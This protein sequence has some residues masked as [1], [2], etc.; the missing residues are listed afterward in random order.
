MG[1]RGGVVGAVPALCGRRSPVLRK[2]NG[3]PSYVVPGAV[4]CASVPVNHWWEGCTDGYR[5]M[6][7]PGHILGDYHDFHLQLVSLSSDQQ[8]LVCW[9]IPHSTVASE[10]TC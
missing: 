6:L 5:S 1:A 7:F 10:C 4:P 8:D 9:R 3:K 2:S